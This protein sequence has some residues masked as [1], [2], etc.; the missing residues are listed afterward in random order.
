MAKRRTGKA[1]TDQFQEG[2]RTEGMEDIERLSRSA[3]VEAK[4][5]N[6]IGHN[7]GDV[8]DEVYKPLVETCQNAFN[9]MQKVQK[10]L[11]KARSTYNTTL[12]AI[13]QKAGVAKKNA[14]KQWLNDKV[15][16]EKDGDGA[17]VTEHR[18]MSRL[19]RMMNDPLGTQWGLFSVPADDQV[20]E[21][22]QKP[23]S[24]ALEP[25][26]AGQAAWRNNEPRTNNPHQAGTEEFVAW[27]TGYGNAQAHHVKTTMGEGGPA[28]GATH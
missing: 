1:T 27:D 15:K 6:G 25:E 11:D 2:A 26:L 23:K 28:E 10:L 18:E 9:E 4:K 3:A 24:A 13:Q 16:R 17:K 20:D 8:S 22:S 7:S 14:V 12:D 21:A 5:K 19:M